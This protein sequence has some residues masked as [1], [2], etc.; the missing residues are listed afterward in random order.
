MKTRKSLDHQKLILEASTQ[1]MRHF[2][3]DPKQARPRTRSVTRLAH[4]THRLRTHS[5]PPTPSSPRP[6]PGLTPASPRADQEAHR[7]PHRARV[8][9][10]RRQQPQPVQVPGL[11]A[12]LQ[13]RPPPYSNPSPRTHALS[14]ATG[15]WLVQALAF[16]G[17]VYRPAGWELE[18]CGRDV[19]ICCLARQKTNKLSYILLCTRLITCV[20][21]CPLFAVYCPTAEASAARWAHPRA[22]RRR[23]RH[24]PAAALAAQGHAARGRRG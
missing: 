7:G 15:A 8:P 3:P 19:C 14:Y 23:R 17:C 21:V 20:L 18:S 6:H 22:A 16:G 12:A 9:R 24:R 11:S 1:L 2:K 10:A 4:P 13:Q 5:R